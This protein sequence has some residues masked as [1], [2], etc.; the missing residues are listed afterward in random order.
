[1]GYFETQSCGCED[2]PCCGCGPDVVLTGQDALDAYY[3][4]QEGDCYNDDYKEYDEDTFDC[5][6][7]YDCDCDY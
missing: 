1:M 5:G 6:C 7:D 3:E 2:Y 4:D